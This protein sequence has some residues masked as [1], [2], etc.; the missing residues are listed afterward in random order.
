LKVYPIIEEAYFL[1]YAPK[2]VIE[3][4]ITTKKDR[5][6]IKSVIEIYNK[7]GYTKIYKELINIFNNNIY[8]NNNILEEPLDIENFIETMNKKYIQYL[9]K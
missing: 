6:Y 8:N 3:N 4:S 9:N 5:I 7:I 2:E 1:L